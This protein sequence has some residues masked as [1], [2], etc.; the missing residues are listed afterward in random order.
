M[1]EESLI[2]TQRSLTCRLLRDVAVSNFQMWQELPR[3]AATVFLLLSRNWETVLFC[4]S[5]STEIQEVHVRLTFSFQRVMWS[6]LFCVSGKKWQVSCWLKFF[7][8][9]NKIE[10]LVLLVPAATSNLHFCSS[11]FNCCL[12]LIPLVAMRHTRVWGHV[13]YLHL[14]VF[15][16]D[17]TSLTDT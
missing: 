11:S 2:L 4:S 12:K 14:D 6:P 10:V 15:W 9:S 16:T 7:K 8:K 5:S 13:D 1:S 17:T 3:E